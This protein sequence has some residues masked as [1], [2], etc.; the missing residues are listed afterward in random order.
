MMSARAFRD[1]VPMGML[2]NLPPMQAV[3][4]LD[5]PRLA[6]EGADALMDVPRR[7]TRHL[8]HRALLLPGLTQS[9]MAVTGAAAAGVTLL[10]LLL[11]SAGDSAP[12][13][14][15]SVPWAML[16][17]AAAAF[18]RVPAAHQWRAVTGTMVFMAL[19]VAASA[20]ALDLG[21]AS[22]MLSVLGLLVCA[23][24]AMAGWHAGM[25][26]A[27]ASVLGIGLVALLSWPAS[28]A[29]GLDLP[30][31]QLVMHLIVLAVGM[32]C[33]TLVARAMAGTLM[34]A[35]ERAE[36]FSRLLALAADA[37][38]EIDQDYRL[39][40]ATAQ[41]ATHHSR[42]SP[43]SLR[44]GL[45]AV[46]WDLPQ[47]SC[48]AVT[49]DDLLADLD[50]R[51]SFRERLVGWTTADGD[52]HHLLISG[53]P[54]FDHRGV[55]TGY[56]GVWRDVTAIASTRLALHA[57]ESRYQQLFSRIPTP[58][59]MH[60]D[61]LVMDANPAALQLFG[62]RDVADMLGTDLLAAF[63]SADARDHARGRLDELLRQPVGTALPVTD[64]KL[65]ICGRAVTVRATGVRVEADDGPALLSIFVDDTERLAG[66][67]NV[68]RSEAMLSH[69]VATSPDLIMLIEAANGRLAMVNQAFQRVSGHAIEA[70]LGRT[71]Q[72]LGLWSADPRWDELLAQVMSV[73]SATDLPVTLLAKD[74]RSLPLR[75]SAAR[76]AMDRRDYV[77]LNAR[78]ISES[79]HAR[80]ERETI[81][82]HASI[83]IAVTRQR[84]FVLA[85]PHFE[86][87]FG[88]APGAL[89]GRSLDA[90][91]GARDA[92][93]SI[94]QRHREALE[95]GQPVSFETTARRLDGSIF[96]A[97]ARA[98]AIDPTRPQE[99][100]TA[101][102]V[103]D[104]TERRAFE[105][106]LAR[107]RDDAEAANRAKSA[108]LA[109]TSHELRTPLNGLIGLARLARDAQTTEAQRQEY[110]A[111]IAESAQSL[112]GIITDILDV[113]KIEAGK[114]LLEATTFD[115]GKLLLALQT[116]YT[117]LAAASG[118]QL[119]FDI[120]PA[121][122]SLVHGDPVRVRQVISNYISNALRFTPSGQVRVRVQR[123]LAETGASPSALTDT[124]RIEVQDTG[125]GIAPAAQTQLFRTF[126]QGDQ[127]STRRFGGTGLGLSINRELAALMGGRVGLVSDLGQ[128]SVFW[129]ELPLPVSQGVAA[130]APRAGGGSGSGSG[131]LQGMRVLMVEDNPVN[132]L[133]A[134]AM[135]E[136]WGVQVTQASNGRDAVEA[137]GLAAAA[138]RQFDA[139]LMDVQ[140]PV[141]NGHEATRELR[142][143]L[144]GHELP[145]IA[146]TAAALVSERE[147]AMRAGMNDFLTK[148]IDAEKL[149]STLLR[150]CAT[151]H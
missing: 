36:R 119:H 113:S 71:A 34:A 104:V 1:T 26:V 140:M 123:V 21:L 3:P 33:G 92:H 8:P 75:V 29:V 131:S 146:L 30:L 79:E 66:E 50:G 6:D 55:F 133:I 73:G 49:M 101:W 74:G 76:F 102:I 141:M 41:D 54:R 90:V 46:P 116:T 108:F 145:I 88:S 139:V 109:N 115:L 16:V 143:S 148:P 122:M 70:T 85:N 42:R 4:V 17:V 87:I 106:T 67:E 86:R 110:M 121:A 15:L 9:L 22:P 68:R 57:T 10:L 137:V 128:G 151:L 31:M 136:R 150:C 97:H 45:G 126:S 59:V 27:G 81:L 43:I 69:L 5:E 107:A 62:Y 37:Y 144:A 124:V 12:A 13:G 135:L 24:C 64:F 147:E 32:A 7:L 99:A 130:P 2:Q 40:S 58:L 96:T 53:E 11:G 63:E 98:H 48:D 117:P 118:L 23:V 18:L 95:Q 72:E 56:W 100:G 129:A 19:L 125:P 111:Q 47:F 83:G 105:Q 94:E 127:S 39:V 89:I 114:L 142:K 103:E 28:P 65:R 78:D 149:R 51:Q 35:G 38:W 112:S 20:W 91:W 80:M 134:V 61:H 25:F 82:T 14:L 84:H 52:T 93:E 77:V 132:M 44:H 120:D 138:G 60:R